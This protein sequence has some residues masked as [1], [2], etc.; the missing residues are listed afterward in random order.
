MGFPVLTTCLLSLHSSVWTS[1][2]SLFFFFLHCLFLL[3]RPVA[4]QLSFSFY[5]FRLHICLC[6]SRQCCKSFSSHPSPSFRRVHF[7][8][9]HATRSAPKPDRQV[10]ERGEDC[11]AGEVKKEKKNRTRV[12]W[13]DTLALLPLVI[14]KADGRTEGRFPGLRR[15]VLAAVCRFW[16]YSYH[17]KPNKQTNKKSHFT[18]LSRSC[19]WKT[20]LCQLGCMSATFW[21]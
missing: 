19:V 21:L 13:W 18:S 16:R 2:L 12:L 11:R 15:G 5:P 17:R 10:H 6:A 3:D 9:A 4:L 20:Q 14:L 8:R 1:G 7:L